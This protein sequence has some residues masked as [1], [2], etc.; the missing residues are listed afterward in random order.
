LLRD[1]TMR[2]VGSSGFKFGTLAHGGKV[3]SLAKLG[4]VISSDD[5][6]IPD[7]CAKKFMLNADRYVR[8]GLDRITKGK[9]NIRINI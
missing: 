1:W 3:L 5:K 9:K 6:P 8:K 4:R 2:K 7:G